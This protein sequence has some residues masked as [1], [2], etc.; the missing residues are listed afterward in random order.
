MYTPQWMLQYPLKTYGLISNNIRQTVGNGASSDPVKSYPL[1][2][3]DSRSCMSIYTLNEQQDTIAVLYTEIYQF[4]Y[5]IWKRGFVVDHAIVEKLLANEPKI[6]CERW[7]E[8]SPALQFRNKEEET[9]NFS[10]P[11]RHLHPFWTTQLPLKW[12]WWMV[13]FTHSLLC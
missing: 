11:F 4:V 1:L 8:L 5:I 6:D 3:K 9:K 10:F 7:E 13:S 12:K 2:K